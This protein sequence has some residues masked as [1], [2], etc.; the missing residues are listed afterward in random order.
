MKKTYLSLLASFLVTLLAISTVMAGTLDID[1]ASI[2][3]SV[4]DQAIGL[5]TLAGS[6]GENIDVRVKFTVNDLD[7]SDS[8]DDEKLEDLKL[9]VWI[10]GYKD[11]IEAS[12][13][14]F[15]VLSGRTYVKDLSLELPNV[16]DIED[17][18]ED[19]TLHVEISDKNDDIDAEYDLTVQRESY[20]YDLLS[21]E[22]P[23]K[24]S[25]G[26]IVAIDVV[27]KNIGGKDLEDSFVT[28]RIPEL[29]IYKKVYFGDIAPEDNF[30]DDDDE[31][32]RERRVY[33]VIPADAISGDY[34]LE[35]KASNYD[36][37]SEVVKSITIEGMSESDVIDATNEDK[38]GIS[39]SVLALTVVLVIIFVVLLIVLIVLLTKKPAE[40]IEDFGET[41]YY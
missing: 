35:V 10:S 31:D 8:D 3:V 37:I 33:L 18:D 20:S 23:V 26:D 1:P 11:D 21:V 17:L 30:D 38:E 14:R 24:A 36:A 34:D 19:L 16:Q 25:A 41:S 15:D 39:N 9:K 12:T 32:A 28:A 22:A 40:R 7:L 2:E 4:N 6:V 13:G 29:G 27:L 5:D